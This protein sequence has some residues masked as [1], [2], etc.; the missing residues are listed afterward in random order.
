MLTISRPAPP[1]HYKLEAKTNREPAGGAHI[2]TW[3][4]QCY[5]Y[6]LQLEP[7]CSA[8]GTQLAE[9]IEKTYDQTN[10]VNSMAAKLA[11]ELDH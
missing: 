1:Q 7:G 4:I 2:I 5:A 3:L 8:T 9:A 11:R 6:L 10:P